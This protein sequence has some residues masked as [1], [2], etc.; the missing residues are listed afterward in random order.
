MVILV[1]F[2]TYVDV[3][4]VTD[5]K[6]KH[7]F[8]M[9]LLSN[10]TVTY[11][12]LFYEQLDHSGA[13][14]GFYENGCNKKTFINADI[15]NK[16]TEQSNIGVS[17]SYVYRLSKLLP[18]TCDIL[19]C[20]PRLQCRKDSITSYA[21]CECITKCNNTNN[22]RIC[23]SDNKSYGSECALNKMLCETFG[24]N[25]TLWNITVSYKGACGKDIL[26]LL[27]H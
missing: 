15:S 10:D 20:S 7:R 19:S 18:C 27:T 4:A 2:V 6:T 23:A 5:D 21:V 17:G 25:T 16:L 11:T 8:Q 12:I 1:L 14:A 24:N 3:S 13:V 9:I 22:D 26:L